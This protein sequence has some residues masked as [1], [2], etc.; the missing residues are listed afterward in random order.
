MT[1][2]SFLCAGIVLESSTPSL[3]RVLV[4]LQPISPIP[5]GPGPGPA[6][7]VLRGEWGPRALGPGPGVEGD[8]VQVHI[9]QG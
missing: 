3:T 1:K 6:R 9:Y 5:Q 4:D 7:K 2:I 8:E